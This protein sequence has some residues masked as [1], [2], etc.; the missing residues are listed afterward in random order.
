V[1]IYHTVSR[2]VYIYIY[3]YICIYAC[4]MYV[5]MYVCMPKEVRKDIFSTMCCGVIS[6]VM[7]FSTVH[8][9]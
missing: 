7:G 8:T 6:M 4:G 9:N 1:V 3:I 5:C 2:N